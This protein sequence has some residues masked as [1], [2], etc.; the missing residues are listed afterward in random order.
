MRN[1]ELLYEPQHALIS[2]K[3]GYGDILKIVRLSP[4]FLKQKGALYIE[5]GYNQHEKIHRLFLEN[6]FIKIEQNRDLNGVIRT[7]SGNIKI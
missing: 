3:E 4:K 6:N 5:H 2:E 1:T 7:T